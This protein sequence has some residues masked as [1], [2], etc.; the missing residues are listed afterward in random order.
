VDNYAGVVVA[1]YGETDYHKRREHTS[2]FYIADA[3][4][5]ALV[6]AN[7]TKDDVD[8]LSVTSFELPPDNTMT[9]AE[10][11]GFSIRWGLH[12]AYG[13][14]SGIIGMAQGAR[15]IQSGDAEV[16]VVVAADAVDVGAH[17]AEIS[18]FNKPLRDY[19][20]PYG[21]A[22]ANGLFALVQRRHMHEHGTTREQLGKLAVTQRFHAS[23]NPNALLRQSMTI[24]DY[25]DARII[26]DPIRLYDCVMPCS[27]GEAV[28]LTTEDR[29]RS[30]GVKPVRILAAGQHHNY[31]P[32]EV[33]VLHQGWERYADQLF[34]QASLEHRDVDLVQ[35]YDDFPIMELIQLE[36][37][38]FCTKGEGGRFLDQT[39][40]S[41]SGKLPI[42]T[43]G[44]QLSAGQCGAGGGLLGPVEAV[45]QLRAEAGRRQVRNARTALIC[46]FGMVAYG[47]GLSTSAMILSA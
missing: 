14:A 18:S 36:N 2:M 22:G 37:L 23:L 32:G 31:H 41:I 4:R 3:I 21:Y 5:R 7:L 13:G 35:L 46:G 15:A 25:L 30:L 27:G 19:V 9:V 29:A 17:N 16:V 10:H 1:G 6:N 43:G 34:N 28:V 26:A 45:R 12:G 44:G 24:D 42:N 38:G 11:L 40:I 8:G 47:R 20:A 39:D 33:V